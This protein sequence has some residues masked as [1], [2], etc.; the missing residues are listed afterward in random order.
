[1]DLTGFRKLAYIIE[2]WARLEI[3]RESY[4]GAAIAMRTGFGMA[5]HL[6]QAPTIIQGLVGGAIGGIMCREVEQ[7]LQGK[8][9]PNLHRALA[10][11]PMPFIDIEKM[12]EF[13]KTV[14][15][16]SVKNKQLREQFEKQMASSLDRTRMNSKRLDNNINGLQCVEAIRH[17]AA[18]HDG[19]LPENLSDIS[20]IEVSNDVVSG[21]AFEYRR[22]S[23][24]ATLQSAI[25]KGGKERD[26]VHYEIILKK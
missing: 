3:S 19:R 13:E 22:T 2:L 6:G 26:A 18:S 8:D 14:G 7:Y 15:L 1:M 20:Q 4:E 23:S 5:R 17:Y 16:G 21:K 24:G 10:E 25:P 9:S 11:L 12:I